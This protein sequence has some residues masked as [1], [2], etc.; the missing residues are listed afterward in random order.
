MERTNSGQKGRRDKAGTFFREGFGSP[1]AAL[2]WIGYRAGL[3]ATGG[4]RVAF[5]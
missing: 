5:Q 2:T 1:Q 3:H 4:L